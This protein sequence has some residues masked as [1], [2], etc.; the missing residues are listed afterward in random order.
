ML[1]LCGW[2]L[3]G[4]FLYVSELYQ[5]YSGLLFVL[6]GAL[7]DVYRECELYGV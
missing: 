3:Y 5:E 1:Y 6:F 4:Y 2:V 7:R